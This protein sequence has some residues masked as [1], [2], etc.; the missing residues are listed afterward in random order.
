MSDQATLVEA[1]IVQGRLD[2]TRHI[3]AEHLGGLPAQDTPSLSG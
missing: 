1:G 2:D 3:L